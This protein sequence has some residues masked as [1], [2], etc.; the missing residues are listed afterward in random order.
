MGPQ[1]QPRWLFVIIAFVLVNGCCFLRRNIDLRTV[2]KKEGKKKKVIKCETFLFLPEGP[3][4]RAH[5]IYRVQKKENKVSNKLLR[6]CV[7]S[8]EDLKT[9]KDLKKSERER[10]SLQ[11]ILCWPPPGQVR[12]TL[13]LSLSF[14]SAMG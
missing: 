5:L 9:E 7:C 12:Y 14:S 4:S 8:L 13:S 11:P 6:H 10:E 3:P 2:Y 1:K